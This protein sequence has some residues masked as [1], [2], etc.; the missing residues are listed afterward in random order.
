MAARAGLSNGALV[1]HFANKANLVVAAT[2]AVYEE[3]I[4]RGRRAALSPTSVKDPVKAGL[5]N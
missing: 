4:L 5:I 3:A 1:H 2:A